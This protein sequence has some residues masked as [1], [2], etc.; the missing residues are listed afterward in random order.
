MSPSK[1]GDDTV[2]RISRTLFL[3]LL[4]V[5]VVGG[6]GYGIYQAGFEQGA[7]GS[8]ADLVER[9]VGPYASGGIA[10][11]FKALFTLLLVGFIAKLFFF[12]R[13]VHHGGHRGD[14]EARREEFKARMDSHLTEWHDRAHGNGGD[15]A[16]TTT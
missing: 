6:L 2:R 15:E 12:R 1:K 13:M 10:L 9:P 4:I 11:V 8:G 3:T 7:L 14:R 5:T 16:P